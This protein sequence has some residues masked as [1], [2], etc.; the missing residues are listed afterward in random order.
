MAAVQSILQ[1][2]GG[3]YIQRE[4]I[5]SGAHLGAGI[6]SHEQEK[7]LLSPPTPLSHLWT[8]PTS[9]WI[10]MCHPRAEEVARQVDAYFLQHWKF[11]NTKSEKVFLNAGFS[12]V[13][14]LYF[15]LAK[16]DRIHF[17][18]RLLTVLF[19]IDDVLEDMSFAD[20]EAYNEKLMPIARGDILPNSEF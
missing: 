13:T 8:P 12:R 7:V 20:G 3:Q 11:C 18:C 2:P 17:A 19:L 10:P 4:D 6:A 14:C 16:D 15:P 1:M 5:S 9:K